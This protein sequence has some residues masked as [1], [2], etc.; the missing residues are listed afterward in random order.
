MWKNLLFWTLAATITVAAAIYQR[1]T[2]PTYPKRGSIELDGKKISYKL[3][4]SCETTKP[5]SIEVP[6]VEG[7]EAY[8]SFKRYKTT[9]TLTVVRMENDGKGNFVFTLPAL[10]PAGKYAYSVFYQKDDRKIFLNESDVVI[11]FKGPVP[12]WI[13]ILHVFFMFF[14]MLLSNYTGILAIAKEATSFVW[15]KRTILFFVI[16][17]FILGP[18]VQKFAFGDFWTGFPFGYDLTDNKVLLT[19]V[20]WLVSWWMF[21]KSQNPRW[22]LVASIITFVIY[23]I[24]HS[25]FGSELDF[26]TGVVK[27]G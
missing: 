17:G 12:G 20:A 18:I 22:F 27:Q 6:T 5:A 23:L 10:P 19:M 24:P 9:D 8:L 11:R 21:N 15:A 1:M 7:Y 4:R 13:L 25:L 26:S 16:G 14:A 2:G 3:L